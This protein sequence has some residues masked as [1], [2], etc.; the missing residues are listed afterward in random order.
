MDSIWPHRTLDCKPSHDMENV[1]N[2]SADLGADLTMTNFEPIEFS[3]ESM[4]RIESEA[5]GDR[6]NP[7][8][9]LTEEEINAKNEKIKQLRDTPLFTPL[10]PVSDLAVSFFI[11]A[12]EGTKF[13]VTE[14][15]NAVYDAFSNSLSGEKTGMIEAFDIALK[16]SMLTFI[17]MNFITEVYQPQAEKIIDHYMSERVSRR[18][19]VRLGAANAELLL[20]AGLGDKEYADA[21]Q[22]DIEALKQGTFSS[23]VEMA[24]ALSIADGA[25]SVADMLDQFEMMLRDRGSSASTLDTELQDLSLLAD[26]WDYFVQKYSQRSLK[27]R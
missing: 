25:C 3:D 24:Q 21:V 27:K 9:A 4:G 5:G 14:L 12:I 10:D 22:R 19:S 18:D 15:A 1:T 2:P 11:L 26:H 16:K 17:K 20:A 13:P 6:Q 8:T 23:Q 7:V